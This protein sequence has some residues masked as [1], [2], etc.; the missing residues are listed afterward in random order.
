MY[1]RMHGSENVKFVKLIFNRLFFVKPHFHSAENRVFS[2]TYM[3]NNTR[4]TKISFVIKPSVS[5]LFLNYL[6]FITVFF[7]WYQI[8][9]W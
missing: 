7:I 5:S 6:S 3:V 1:T 8:D 2:E 9:N 4:E